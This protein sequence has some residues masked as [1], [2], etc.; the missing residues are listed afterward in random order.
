MSYQTAKKQ[1]KFL[2]ILRVERGKKT[3]FRA[4]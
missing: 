2:K 1:Q 4:Q 3:Y